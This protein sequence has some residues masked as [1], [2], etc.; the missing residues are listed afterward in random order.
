MFLSELDALGVVDGGR[1]K[2]ERWRD[3]MERR[4]LCD[5][6]SRALQAEW[7]ESPSDCTI[8]SIV[9][10]DDDDVNGCFEINI[11]TMILY[12]HQLVPRTPKV[13]TPLLKQ[14]LLFYYPTNYSLQL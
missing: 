8:L 12:L 2:M 10:V 9:C 6:D 14:A 4:M 13:S 7:K 11:Y 3:V 5:D 1:W